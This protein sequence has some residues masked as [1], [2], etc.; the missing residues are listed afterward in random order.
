M[1]VINAHWLS[2]D[3]QQYRACIEFVEIDG[4]HSGE[5]LANIVATVLDRFHISAKVMTITAD[6]ASN[7]DTLHRFLYQ[8]LSERYD[9]YLSEVVIQEGTMR[10]TQ[11]SQICCFAHI[12]NLV[13]K[14]ILRSLQASSYKE[15]AALLNDIAKK[16][17]K[18][19]KAPTA[20][21][22]KLRLLVLWI[23][24]SP[25]RIQKWDNR[26]GCTKAINYDIDTRWN[27]TFLMIRDAIDCRRQ[28][29]DT[30]N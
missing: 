7:N 10:F 15:A 18:T 19:I 23:A 25:Q 2:P 24:R 3:F 13:M 22:A 30:V 12:L 16:S 8:K 28:L 14:S 9:E 21:I 4:A 29:E 17:W 11:N 1:L 5:N 26:P 27:S 6:N 20:P